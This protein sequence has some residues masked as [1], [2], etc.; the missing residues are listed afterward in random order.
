MKFDELADY[1]TKPEPVKEARG[2]GRPKMAQKLY[3]PSERAYEMDLD[4]DSIEHAI[5][6]FLDEAPATLDELVDWMRTNF[7]EYYSKSAAKEQIRQMLLNQVLDF[8]G[9]E[10]SSDDDEKEVPALDFDDSD[11]FEPNLHDYLEP[12]A[13]DDYEHSSGG[14]N[15]YF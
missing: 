9:G 10:T 5:V 6:Q 8:K 14:G 7:D 13:L 12:G 2:R 3:V 15:E 4:P 11:G 1:Y